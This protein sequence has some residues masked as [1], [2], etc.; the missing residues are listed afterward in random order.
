[1]NDY[2]IRYKAASMCE[3]FKVMYEVYPEW[4][5]I[6]D[7]RFNASFQTG[8]C[9]SVIDKV[10]NADDLSNLKIVFSQKNIEFK[11]SMNIGYDDMMFYAKE[12]GLVP[13]FVIEEWLK[14]DDIHDLY[15]DEMKELSEEELKGLM[16]YYTSRGAR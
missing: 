6:S 2:D 1:M 4:I 12:T 5:N 11:P 9:I 15:I 10:L 8:I 13:L 14:R 16:L 3:P 7:K